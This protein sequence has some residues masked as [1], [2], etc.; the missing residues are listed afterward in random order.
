MASGLSVQNR[1]PSVL[2]RSTTPTVT[3]VQRSSESI[4]KLASALAKAQAELVNPE[5]SLVAIIRSEGAAGQT[6]RYAPL[7]SGLDIVRKTL[8]NHEIAV[9]QT[10][11]TDPA[12]GMI[13]L[14]TMLAHASGEWIA[15]DWPVC[16]IAETATPHRMGAALTY[17]RRYALFT[18]VG[19]AGEDDLDAP[20]LAVPDPQ[21][22][23]PTRGFGN[24]GGG[25]IGPGNRA[26]G[27]SW[28]PAS[29]TAQKARPNPL[30][31]RASAELR[32]NLVAEIHALGG[33][34]EATAWA[35]RRMADKNRLS[36]ADARKIEEAFQHRTVRANGSSKSARARQ[37][38]S[39]DK[40]ALAF[41]EPRRV[42]DRDHVRSVAQKPCLVCGRQPSD[43]HHLRFAQ[44]R[45]MGRKVSDEFTVPLC[46][47]HHRELHH[48]GDEATWWR[49]QGIDPAGAARSLWL[50]SHPLPATVSGGAR[51]PPGPGDSKRADLRNEANREPRR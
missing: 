19:I 13:N 17:A 5:K 21:A 11:S 28:R 23:P 16:Q 2:R 43:P 48:C 35:Q 3:P 15:S 6:F 7:S 49:K 14:T 12:A 37:G 40:S 50:E 31:G 26:I 46:R 29:G 47:G 41:P 45:A 44:S 9:V 18:L 32:D 24:G 33:S 42:R 27:P 38:A 39:I 25:L 51:K 20:D 34:D 10:T 30:D 22:G 1:A 36:A 8:G 4:A